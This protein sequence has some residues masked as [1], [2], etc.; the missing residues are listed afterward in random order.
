MKKVVSSSPFPLCRIAG[1]GSKPG[2]FSHM[3]D[4]GGLLCC[5][6]E[7]VAILSEFAGGRLTD[8]CALG[9]VESVVLVFSPGFGCCCKFSL[10]LLW[11]CFLNGERVD[12][13]TFLFILN[14]QMGFRM[15]SEVSL[16]GYRGGRPDSTTV[17][18]FVCLRGGKVLFVYRG[19]A[20]LCKLLCNIC[21]VLLCGR[22]P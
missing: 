2:L 14:L 16:T 7:L 8:C 10:R 6:V 15:V 22:V 17:F 18:E 9:W 13:C 19:V 1:W 4:L 20:L 21:R 5:F 3:R 11:I 12:F